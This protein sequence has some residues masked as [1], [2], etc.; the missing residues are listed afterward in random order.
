MRLIC[1]NCGAQY[2]VEDDVIPHDGRDVQ[3]SNCGHT[4]FEGPDAPS[5]AAEENEP[6]PA[7]PEPEPSATKPPVPDTAPTE[8]AAPNPEPV[9]TTEPE[10]EIAAEVQP[11]P[12]ANTAATPR[13]PLD[14]SIADILREEAAR[15]E[16][17][18]R[19]D[20]DD[21]LQSQGDLGLTDPTPVAIAKPKPPLQAAADPGQE[22]LDRLRGSPSG[23]IPVAGARSEMFP[24]IEEINSSLRSSAERGP[25]AMLPAEEEA[26]NRRSGRMGFFSMLILIIILMAIYVYAEPIAQAIPA[27]GDVLSSY[28]TTVDQARLWLDE[29]VQALL[30]TADNT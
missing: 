5:V 14:S 29:K 4:W 25:M 24:D 9:A 30:P 7:A 11:A 3:C 23:A 6:E 17:A 19:A 15:E 28:V 20:T 2:E 26:S 16:A 12:K 27:L 10:P 21:G 13:P 8:D 18:R 1:P 22:R